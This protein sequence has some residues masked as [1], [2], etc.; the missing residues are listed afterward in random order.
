MTREFK[1]GEYGIAADKAKSLLDKGIGIT[2]IISMTGLTE[3]R[4]NKLHKKM[5]DKLT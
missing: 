5:R 1:K 2:E 4:I 3:E